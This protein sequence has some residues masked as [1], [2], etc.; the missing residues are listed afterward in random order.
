M[1]DDTAPIQA[2][3][4]DQ[5]Q[6]RLAQHLEMHDANVLLKR[7]MQD[8]PVQARDQVGQE[9]DR[10]GAALRRIRA[11]VDVVGRDVGEV[12]VGGVLLHVELVDEVE[13]DGVLL[14]GRDRFG[15]AE[16]SFREIGGGMTVVRSWGRQKGWNQPEEGGNLKTHGAAVKNTWM[17]GMFVCF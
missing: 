15:R 9:G 10:C 5:R 4:I 12:G 16:G 8:R 14:R 7:L 3:Q 13:E 6:Q 1:L 17:S 11:V 2:E